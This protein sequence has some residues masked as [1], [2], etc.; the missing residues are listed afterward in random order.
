MNA[1]ADVKSSWKLLMFMGKA[2]RGFWFPLPDPK[3]R[4][5][6]VGMLLPEG[7]T[8][9]EPLAGVEPGTK[10]GLPVTEPD[11]TTAAGLDD[12]ATVAGFDVGATA[13]AFDD[14]TT[15]ATSELAA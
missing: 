9:G 11:G 13:A 12:G 2:G 10:T 7:L 15:G 6:P 14:G 5:W 3:P 8:V 4:F 1:N